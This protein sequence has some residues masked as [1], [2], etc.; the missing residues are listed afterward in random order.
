MSDQYERNGVKITVL[1][2]GFYELPGGE[3]VRGKEVADARADEIAKAS[4]AGGAGSEGDDGSTINQPASLDALQQAAVDADKEAEKAA[5][6][7]KA[8]DDEISA[9]KAQLAEQTQERE[10]LMAAAKNAGDVVTTIESTEGEVEGR[11][12]NSIPRAFTGELD[13]KTKA[14][15][16][17]VGI[18]T[19]RIV[20]EE[21]SDIPPTGLFIGHNGRG[22]VITPGVEVDVPE[23]LLGV[24]GDAKMSAPTV[25]S[26]TMKVLGYRDR[27]RYPYR[28]VD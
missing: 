27:M 13:K 18:K 7:D 21:S 20:L 8:K 14:E 19:R 11:V 6:R 15:L 1:G 16:G 23:F 25:D 22:Y 12:P 10:K 4:R 3:K 9:L 26:K 5:E 17:K 2:G 28:L 24:L